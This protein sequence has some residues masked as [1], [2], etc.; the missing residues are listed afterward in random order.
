VTPTGDRI[1][2]TATPLG[3]NQVK[4]TWE[5]TVTSTEIDGFRFIRSTSPN[6]EFDRKNY[7]WETSSVR[8]ETTWREIVAGTYHMRA[9]VV[10]NDVCVLYSDDQVVDVR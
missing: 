1:S 5:T 10:R 4:L 7:W 3:N 9:C 2:F 8:R 6:P